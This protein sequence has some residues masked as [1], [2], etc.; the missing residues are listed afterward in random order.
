MREERYF[1]VFAGLVTVE[2]G[3]KWEEFVDMNENE[4]K[5]IILP[6]SVEPLPASVLLGSQITGE[7]NSAIAEE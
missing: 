1:R 5:E 4:G 7:S 2:V 3:R 6:M